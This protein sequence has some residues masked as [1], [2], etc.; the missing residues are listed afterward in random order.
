MNRKLTITLAV[1]GFVVIAAAGVFT[2]TSMNT[3]K[4]VEK[5]EKTIDSIGYDKGSPDCGITLD[6]ET[7]ISKARKAYDS[8]DSSI[9]KKVKN[10]DN[11]KNS[12]KMLT[13]LQ[14]KVSEVEGKITDIGFDEAAENCGIT[15]DSEDKI[16]AARENYNKLNDSLKKSVSNYDILEKSEKILED[17]KKAKEEEEARIKAEAEAKAKAEA[18]AKA[19]AEA[20]A[21]KNTSSNSG[22]TSNYSG[23]SN[24]SSNELID[25]S[26]SF[27]V[28]AFMDRVGRQYSPVDLHPEIPRQSVTID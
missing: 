19:K 8:A 14:K 4:E 20:E 7:T 10:Y 2:Y 26:G 24:N 15:L 11:L 5:I 21:R 13:S 3:K 1:I 12:E 16:V 9:Q 28:N 17:L 6:S 18:E 25:S 22:S 27:D 23:G